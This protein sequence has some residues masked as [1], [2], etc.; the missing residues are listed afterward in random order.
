[1]CFFFSGS[2]LYYLNTVGFIRLAS[3]VACSAAPFTYDR[4]FFPFSALILPAGSQLLRLSTPPQTESVWA[5]CTTPNSLQSVEV[6][7]SPT[8]PPSPAFG[9]TP[10]G[11]ISPT[12]SVIKSLSTPTCVIASPANASQ[13]RVRPDLGA[14]NKSNAA[15]LD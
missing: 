2:L 7:S 11:G 6:A 5:P 14:P 10:N 15:G 13:A 4:H 12:T 9:R 1:M 3:P 8:V